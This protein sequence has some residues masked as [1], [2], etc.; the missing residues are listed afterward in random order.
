MLAIRRKRKCL[1]LGKA[2]IAADMVIPFGV[3]QR[4][5]RGLSDPV[6]K[7]SHRPHETRYHLHF[8][9]LVEGASWDVAV[10]VG[11]NDA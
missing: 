5:T 6:M 7:P 9:L 1:L 10:N 3:P 8:S 2:G 11:T 4:V